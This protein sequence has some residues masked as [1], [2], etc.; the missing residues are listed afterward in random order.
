MMGIRMAEPATVTDRRVDPMP[1]AAP[2]DPAGSS[3]LRMTR[4]ER[5]WLLRV[6]E[7]LLPRGAD[8]RIPFGAADVPMGRFVDDLLAE[9]PLEFIA[10]LRLCLWMLMLAPLVVLRRP[11]SFLGVGP[12]EQAAVLER[13]R[14]SDVYVVREAPMLLKTIACLGF[15]G[16][17]AIQGSIGIHPIDTSPPSWAAKDGRPS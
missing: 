7:A 5:R 14:T 11:R 17:P 13:L 10:G 3:L 8:P 6:F 9:S 1:L 15:C 16:V 12:I 2:S 4:F